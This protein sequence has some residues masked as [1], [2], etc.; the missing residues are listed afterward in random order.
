ME[1][2]LDPWLQTAVLCSRVAGGAPSE[3]RPQSPFAEDKRIDQNVEGMKT[4]LLSMEAAYKAK[5]ER[6]KRK[7]E[8]EQKNE[9]PKRMNDI[10]FL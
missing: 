10:G 2:H 3:H 4:W 8:K 9:A 7:Q 5:K 1:N 6:Q